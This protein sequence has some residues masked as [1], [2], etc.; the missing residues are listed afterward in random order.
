MNEFTT[1]PL[2]ATQ[3]PDGQAG[4]DF[5]VPDTDIAMPPSNDDFDPD[6][7][8]MPSAGG[9]APGLSSMF[10]ADGAAPDLSAMPSDGEA[11]PDLT[12]MPPVGE[13][14][15]DFS[16]TPPADEIDPDFSVVPPVYPIDPDFSVTPPAYPGIPS[17]IPCLFC[18]SNQWLRGAIRLLNA[19]TGYNAFNVLIDGRPVSRSLNFPE[20][21]QYRQLPQGY[22]VF[23]VMGLNG[24]TYVRKTMY[25]GDSMA[26]VAIINAPTGLDLT[27]IEDTACPADN[28][29][30]C[31][32]VCNL[33][34]YS[35]PVNAVIGNVYFNAVNFNTAAS[36]S[37]FG[38]GTYTLNISRSARPE[39]ILVSTPVTLNRR[40]IYTAYVL[41]W[42]ASPD[43][44]QTL[45]VEDRR[46]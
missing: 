31:F 24:Y 34:Y 29:S 38:A 40:R 42:N 9:T 32:R 8:G 14:D 19:A 21:T 26:T 39:T 37:T 36:F 6:F 5:S 41:N 3:V 11:A 27:M 33:A 10:P 2:R 1:L 22:H 30:A 13:I 16:V 7:S 23:T 45:L 28:N 25:V 46:G 12:A 17:F 20:I 44:I 4:E 15:P 35:G 43:T 18:S